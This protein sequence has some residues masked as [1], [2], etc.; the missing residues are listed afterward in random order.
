MEVRHKV[1]NFAN[2]RV[3]AETAARKKYSLRGAE[4]SLEEIYDAFPSEFLMPDRMLQFELEAESYFLFGNPSVV[5]IITTARSLGKRVIAISDIYLSAIQVNQL[6]LNAGVVVDKV[7][8]SA[9]FRAENVGKYNTKAFSHIARI[10]KID[11][12]KFLHVGDNPISDVANATRSGMAALWT[13]NLHKEVEIQ[14]PLAKFMLDRAQTAS[15]RIIIGQVNKI[16]ACSDY[17][18]VM[19]EKLGYSFGGPLVLGFLDYI[20]ST[21][22]AQGV[23]KLILLERDGCIIFEAARL[24][25]E[26]EVPMRLMPCS[27]RLSALP[28][29]LNGNFEPLLRIFSN[30][31]IS[32]SDF[33]AALVL[34]PPTSVDLDSKTLKP[35]MAHIENNIAFLTQQ[36][37]IELYAIETELQQELHMISEGHKIAWIDVGWALSSTSALNAA[38]KI[39]VSCYC[40]GSNGW[41]APSL[42]H[43]GYLFKQN[44]PID[45]SAP[46]NNGIELIELIFSDKMPS[47]AFLKLDDIGITRISKPQP[48]EEHIRNI[49]IAATHKGV[50]DFIKDI[51]ELRLGISMVELR[52]LNRRMA[53]DLCRRPPSQLYSTIER[54]PHDRLAGNQGWANVGNYWKP[55]GFCEDQVNPFADK[56]QS[57]LIDARSRPF[58]QIFNLMHF[59]LLQIL[60]IVVPTLSSRAAKRFARSAEK[61]NP[62]R[63]SP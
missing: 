24:L 12:S 47:T 44:N 35:A 59:K 62:N 31:I 17:P 20:Q 1:K 8:T 14:D 57:Q 61:R 27:R 13:R 15:D 39:D 29:L 55:E 28:C 52:D 32:E 4:V 38:L 60:S 16:T 56:L 26:L 36:A 58:K 63:L 7:Y 25:P 22:R 9:D 53:A 5:D 34:P 40:I 51:A 21:A 3:H 2:A 11:Q 41:V 48:I 46:V 33:F 45:V 49:S 23:E 10:E 50:L 42:A 19:E 37:K 43:E 30:K 18:K 6:L 54:I